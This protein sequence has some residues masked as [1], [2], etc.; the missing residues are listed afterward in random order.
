MD[1]LKSELAQCAATMSLEE[2]T[3]AINE[4]AAAPYI[5]DPEAFAAYLKTIPAS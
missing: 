5:E 2:L 3:A 4:S 1:E